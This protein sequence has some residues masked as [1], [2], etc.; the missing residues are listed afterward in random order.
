MDGITI[1]PV[2]AGLS[3]QKLALV[4]LA[5]ECLRLGRPMVLP[6]LVDY[7]PPASQH[8]EL[9]FDAVFDADAFAAATPRA[10]LRIAPSGPADHL[11]DPHDAFG[12]GTQHLARIATPQPT[13]AGFV[14]LGGMRPN[15]RI[16][17]RV[18]EVVA[19][20]AQR[21]VTAGLQLRIEN[22]WQ[23]Y[24]TLT[25]HERIDP[26]VEEIPLTAARI[27]D[28]I[29]ASLG[30]G[31]RALYVT[32]NEADLPVPREEIR[33][34]AATRHGFE[35]VFKS[36]IVGEGLAAASLLEQAIVDFE[37][38]LSLPAMIGLTR[39]TF[40]N[41]AAATAFA[42]GST[43][44]RRFH[45]YN[46][47]GGALVPRTDHGTQWS[48]TRATA[49]AAPLTHT[50]RETNMQAAAAFF[51]KYGNTT[52]APWNA[53]SNFVAKEA[54]LF[55]ALE[56]IYGD[57]VQP[58]RA[59]V[60]YRTELGWRIKSGRVKAYLET[61]VNDG[62]SLRLA[63]NLEVAIGIDPSPRVPPGSFTE[64]P[65]R[66]VRKS[67]DNFFRETFEGGDPG[68]RLDLGFVDGLHIFEYA[69]RDFIGCEALAAPG[70][71]VLVHDV[72]PR[73]RAEAARQRFTRS[74]TG[75]VWRLPLVLRHFRPDLKVR[76]L[77]ADP[78]GL[79]IIGRLNP[80]STLLMDRYEEVV[81]HGLSLSVDDFM[82]ERDRH[83]AAE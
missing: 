14:L 75:D 33:A 34:E 67:S 5:T 80:A 48:I 52:A 71:E 25:L 49:G 36:D 81:A 13:Q 77:A 11:L 10:G 65:F 3:N 63:E 72:L 60:A 6:A 44:A 83:V 46:A 18:T 66:L 69:L 57:R 16:A 20:L 17:A 74:W 4:G 47:A 79:A 41:V 53:F 58:L 27:L 26:K 54:E 15:A 37:V 38:A 30:A 62:G 70:C 32:C 35:L 31:P 7:R 8:A 9:P 82:R 39:S 73:R 50:T 22:D 23:R 2:K 51:T 45:V 12:M 1:P 28:K 43:P 40:F 68:F 56:E 42:R 55:A 19:R 78:T 61:G 21:G 24:F 64:A 76:L 29:A 59:T